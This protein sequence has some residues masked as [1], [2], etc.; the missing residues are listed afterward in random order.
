MNKQRLLMLVN[1]LRNNVPKDESR[2]YMGTWAGRTAEPFKFGDMLDDAS[3]GTSGCAMG[4]AT[5]IPHFKE[6]GLFLLGKTYRN[7]STAE[8]VY[9]SQS[10]ARYHGFDAVHAFMDLTSEQADYL[11][12]ANQ[13]PDLVTVSEVADRIENFVISNGEM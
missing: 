12:D 13:Y 1:H 5:T 8:L 6:L 2:F 3:C 4:W 7:A 9:Q 11:F 10:G